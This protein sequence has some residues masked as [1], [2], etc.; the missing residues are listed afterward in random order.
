MLIIADKTAKRMSIHKFKKMI[1][2]SHFDQGGSEL[3]QK[4]K[5]VEV[6]I[7]LALKDTDFA[8]AKVFSEKLEEM[9]K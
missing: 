2:S 4:K 5:S 7:A 3:E 1:Y 9:M 8:R 6:K